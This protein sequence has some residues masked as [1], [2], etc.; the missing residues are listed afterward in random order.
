MLAP[1]LSAN[2]RRRALQC[3]IPP[4]ANYHM[5]MEGVNPTWENP[6]NV[7]GGKWVFA[8]KRRQVTH[9]YPPSAHIFWVPFFSLPG[10]RGLCPMLRSATTL[11]VVGGIKQGRKLAMLSGNCGVK[12]TL[13]RGPGGAN[14]Y[15]ECAC[16]VDP[17][18]T[19]TLKYR[20]ED[21]EALNPMWLNTL[22]CILGEQF[23]GPDNEQITGAVFSVRK[24]ADRVAL[25]SKTVGDS[26]SSGSS[27]S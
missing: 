26:S 27:A 24:T 4:S 20:R 3:E 8:T 6:T 18:N 13:A 22:M 9:F 1:R 7:K 10:L 19:E 21:R 23:D 17:P 16:V 5:F 11:S 12:Q 14:P 25:W 2:T 15:I